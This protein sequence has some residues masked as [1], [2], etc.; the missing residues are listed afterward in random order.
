LFVALGILAGPAILTFAQSLHWLIRLVMAVAFLGCAFVFP[1][2]YEQ[3]P[4]YYWLTM[5]LVF[6]EVFW[7]IPFYSKYRK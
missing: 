5:L 7:L 4:I 6:V 1:W 2:F 3:L